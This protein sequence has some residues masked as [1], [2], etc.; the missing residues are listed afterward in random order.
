M[1]QKSPSGFVLGFVAEI[2][3][4]AAVVAILPKVP[5]GSAG[6]LPR[7]EA[8]DE[9]PSL[10]PRGPQFAAPLPQDHRIEPLPPPQDNWRTAVSRPASSFP[11]L[12]DELPPSDPAYVEQRLDAAGQQLLEGVAGYFSRQAEE[13]LQREPPSGTELDPLPDVRERP[14]GGFAPQPRQPGRNRFRY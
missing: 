7:A 3:I 10:A 11:V 5:L 6:T 9:R 12:T 8:A 2:A 13:L 1:S 4:V 14:A